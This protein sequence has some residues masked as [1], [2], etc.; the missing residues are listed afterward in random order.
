MINTWSWIVWVG[1]VLIGLWS[2]RNPLYLGLIFL[3]LIINW[4]LVKMRVEKENPEPN[5]QIP[6]SPLKISLFIILFSAIFNGLISQFGET[7]IFV[8][9]NWIPYLGG[10][11]T[12]EGLV[13]GAI[14]GL[15]LSGILTAFFVINLALPVYS[16]VR[17]IPG[18]FYPDGWTIRTDRA[19]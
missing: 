13:Y 5:Y 12:L 8:L 17:L 14:N 15:V 7:V 2:T 16:L 19:V 18:A 9:P 3:I 4:R 1:A 6:F 10:P 11:I